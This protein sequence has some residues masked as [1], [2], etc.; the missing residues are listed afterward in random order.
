MKVICKRFLNLLYSSL[1]FYAAYVSF[2]TLEFQMKSVR[3]L[4][5]PLGA[6]LAVIFGAL[7][8]IAGFYFLWRAFAKRC[9]ACGR[10]H[11]YNMETCPDCVRARAANSES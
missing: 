2:T 4:S 8:G 11:N 7:Y 10:I 9:G 3:R 5:G 1:G 6:A